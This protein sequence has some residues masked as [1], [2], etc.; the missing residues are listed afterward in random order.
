M[1]HD[2]QVNAFPEQSKQRAVAVSHASHSLV[3]SFPKVVLGQTLTHVVPLKNS[4][5]V[6]PQLSHTVLSVSLHDDHGVS[7]NSHSLVAE[8]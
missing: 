6:F 5:F 1:L 2:V 7:Q 3:V 4:K 8:L